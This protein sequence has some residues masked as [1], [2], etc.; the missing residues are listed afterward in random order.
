ML[1]ARLL[2]KALGLLLFGVVLGGC[3]RTGPGASG[4]ESPANRAQTIRYETDMYAVEI[5]QRENRNGVCERRVALFTS[6]SRLYTRPHVS[7]VRAVDMGCD[8]TY[9]TAFEQL[10]VLRDPEQERRYRGDFAFRNRVDEDLWHAYQNAL[11]R[12]A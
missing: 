12:G 7:R 4:E 3:A 6:H 2:P 10:E 9:T 5:Q 8:A 1:P 11:F